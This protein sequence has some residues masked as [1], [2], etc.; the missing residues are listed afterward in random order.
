MARPEFQYPKSLMERVG[1]WV[2]QRLENLFDDLPGVDVPAGSFGGGAGSLIGWLLIILA[3]AAVL[4]V[5]VVAVRHWVP[6][7]DDD[8]GKLSE[9]EAEHRRRASEWARE[10]Q[11]HEGRGEWKLA[12]RARYRELV[13]TLV[14]RKQVADLAGLTTRELLQDVATTTPGATADFESA[15]M[16]FELPWYADVPTGPVENARIRSLSEAVLAEPVEQTVDAA[17]VAAA[18]RVE[19]EAP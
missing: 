13:R 11:D 19:V 12:M 1:D 9:A 4:A 5:V 14:D 16:L 18:G 17:M 6:R 8:S 3:L 15:C 7:V 2:A 10:A